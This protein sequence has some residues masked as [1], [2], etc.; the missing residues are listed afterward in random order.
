MAA[1]MAAEGL[2]DAALVVVMGILPNRKGN[3]WNESLLCILL[4]CREMKGL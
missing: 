2:V 1:K 4:Q 3:F